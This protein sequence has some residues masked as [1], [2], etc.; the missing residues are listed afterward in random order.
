MSYWAEGGVSSCYIG[1]RV[2]LVHVIL[3]GWETRFILLRC[4]DLVIRRGYTGSG[5]W[6]IGG[7]QMR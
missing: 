1:W 2:E 5:M 6:E 4:A 7:T 3:G